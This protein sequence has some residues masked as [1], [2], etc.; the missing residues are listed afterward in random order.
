MY[1]LT[2]YMSYFKI[3]TVEIRENHSLSEVS[4]RTTDSVYFL[5]KLVMNHNYATMQRNTL[6]IFDSFLLLTTPI[7]R[8]AYTLIKENQN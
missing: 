5:A 6:S 2:N 4:F 3:G 7:H 8:K 1:A